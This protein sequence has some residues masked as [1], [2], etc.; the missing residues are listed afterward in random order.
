MKM[1]YTHLINYDEKN[2]SKLCYLDW[3][4]YNFLL[5]VYFIDQT[6]LYNDKDVS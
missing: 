5:C 4:M 3:I 6:Y 2:F 1:I